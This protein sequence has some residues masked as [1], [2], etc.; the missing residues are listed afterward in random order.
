MYIR[1]PLIFLSATLAIFLFF[2]IAYVHYFHQELLVGEFQHVRG[3][4]GLVIPDTFLYK[5]AINP[6]DVLSSILL[7]AMKNSIVPC[8]IWWASGY[9]WYWVTVVNCFLLFGAILYLQKIFAEYHIH[10]SRSRFFGIL[11]MLLPMS[12]YYAIGSLK[13]IPSLLCLT[14]FFYYYIS[15]D[16]LRVVFFATLLIIIRYQFAVVLF[17]FILMD[18]FK[19]KAISI[20]VI[21][22]I[23]IGVM[24]PFYERF[25]LL[26]PT[27]TMQ[28]REETGGVGSIGSYVEIIRSEVPFISLFAIII[29]IV[30]SVYE[31][32]IGFMKSLSL[33]E[34][35]SLS[36]YSTAGLISNLIMF[37]ILIAFYRR[38]VFV[39]RHR[40]N[41]DRDTG[42]LFII[43][44]VS[45]FGI[46]GLSFIHGRYL[47]PLYGLLLVASALPRSHFLRSHV[48]LCVC[49]RGV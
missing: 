27:A 38:C 17:L 43:L 9:D 22:L 1:K 41:I 33:Y 45:L 13:E 3:Y 32:L 18:I 14:A 44:F 10:K 48:K 19:R 30:Q 20:T 8:F 46:G 4:T 29:R 7:S 23:M 2:D 47:Y 36:V 16:R 24:Y 5:Q 15:G 34:K 49:Q 6:D 25:D 28:Y 39:V 35:G 37:S 21:S 26:V 31:P 11:L 12:L 42:R 40:N